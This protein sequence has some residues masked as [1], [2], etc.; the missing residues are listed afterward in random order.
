METRLYTPYDK[1]E[2][3]QW[4]EAHNMAPIPEG[5]LPETGYLVQGVAAGFLYRTDSGVALV[6]NFISNPASAWGVR[7]EALDAITL[8]LVH[9]AQAGGFSCLIALTTSQAIHDRAVRLGFRPQG[10]YQVLN[11]HLSEKR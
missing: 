9:H 2:L 11:M 1:A 4:W 6:E 10:P 3:D 5:L 8:A 7:Q